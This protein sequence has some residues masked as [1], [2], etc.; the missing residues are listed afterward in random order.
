MG[1]QSKAEW[2]DWAQNRSRSWTPK[3]VRRVYVPKA[4]G[5]Q[6]PIGIPV[7]GD[8]ILQALASSA[9]EPEWEARF[10][11]KSYGFRPG[12]GCHDA[13]EAIFN[14]VHGHNP[15]RRWILAT[16]TWRRRSTGLI[17]IT[18]SAR[19]ARFPPGGWSSGG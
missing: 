4:G 16:Q 18:S 3:P 11:P 14:T 19:S 13:I 7:I 10:E 9:L 6:R 1:S 17:T 8:R 5:K 12:R 2:A 15:Q